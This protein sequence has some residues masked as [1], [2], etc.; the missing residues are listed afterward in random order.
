M[1]L[2]GAGI[3]QSMDDIIDK[4]IDAE[5]NN[6]ELLPIDAPKLPDFARELRKHE[7]NK[8][9]TGSTLSRPKPSQTQKQSTK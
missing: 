9:M 1:L 8:G 4:K 3:N 7:K 5:I 2:L 6:E